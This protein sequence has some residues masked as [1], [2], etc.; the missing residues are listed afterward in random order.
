MSTRLQGL[1]AVLVTVVLAALATFAPAGAAQAD[2]YTP[3]YGSGSTWS[4]NAI[5]QWVREVKKFGITVSYGGGG[6]STGRS[7][8]HQG[9]TD[10]GV[11]EIPYQGVD[12]LSGQPDVSDR[13]YAYMPIV[14][15]GTTFMYNL[16]VGGKQLA[17]LRLSGE[18]IAK[19][20]TGGIRDWSDPAI[21]K[22]N[23]GRQLPKKKIVPV[24]RSDGSGTTAQFT[25]WMSKQYP[26]IWNAYTKRLTGK[27]GGMTSYY[28]SD[29]SIGMLGQPNSTQLAGF[30]KA[31][32]GDGTIGY[33]E[34]SYA[35]DFT[36]AKVL[37]KAGYY[38]EPTDF[39]VA[40][41]LQH[42][43]LNTDK[44]NPRLYLTQVLDGVYA[45]PEKQAYPLSSYSYMIIPTSQTGQ[46]PFERKTTPNTGRTLS[47][48]AYYFLCEG[49][50]RAGE[51]GYSPLPAN[52]VQAGLQQVARIPGSERKPVDIKGCNNPTFD[53]TNLKRNILVEKA[54]VPPVCDAVGQGPCGFTASG[55]GKGGGGAPVAAAPGAAPVPGASPKPGGKAPAAGLPA[56]AAPVPGAAPAAGGTTAPAD[57][58]APPVAAAGDAQ[59]V[60]GGSELAGT[61]TNL[62]G[63]RN[64][65]S[66]IGVLAAV[67]A[68]LILAL[69]F[70]PAIA[71]ALIRRR[72]D[73]R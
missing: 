49:Q 24:V 22:D 3:I 54:P 47:A 7:Q 60:A 56:A 29:K 4:Q 19:I 14:A 10:F 46:N 72:R 70:T 62:G 31:A 36:Y 30:I 2:T 45:A 51:L 63:A 42:A 11:S 71:G 53:G 32:Y 48:F 44:S 40:V 43:R 12:P 18:T 1:R 73:G 65:G 67:S 55:I 57:P 64:S 59:V 28:P 26:D 58:E 39:N 27:A 68:A 6:S 25:L 16:K 66:M 21:T 8:F 15:G 17:G 13:P 52:L 33:V 41:A 20:F 61:V 9:V 50:A 5:D 35:K 34:Y 23:N 69:L 38:T 37:N